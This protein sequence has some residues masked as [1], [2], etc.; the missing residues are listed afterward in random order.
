MALADDVE[1][2]LKLHR[3]G[4]TKIPISYLRTWYK[5]IRFRA[6]RFSRITGTPLIGYVVVSLVLKISLGKTITRSDTDEC[7]NFLDSR[8]NNLRKW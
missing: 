7:I 5:F 6:K 8:S 1:L 2:S 3:C 4:H